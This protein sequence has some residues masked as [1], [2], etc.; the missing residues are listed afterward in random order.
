MAEAHRHAER[1]ALHEAYHAAILAERLADREQLV[2]SPQQEQPA[3]LARRL[4]EQMQTAP[5][6]D[7]FGEISIAAVPGNAEAAEA[8][9]LAAPQFPEAVRQQPGSAPSVAAVAPSQRPAPAATGFNDA[10]PPAQEWR[11]VKAN[12][13]VSLAVVD[14]SPTPFRRAPEPVTHAVLNAPAD[15]PLAGS[16]LPRH[17]QAPA[18]SLWTGRPEGPALTGGPE[19]PGPALTHGTDTAATSASVAPP[20]PLDLGAEHRRGTEP[21]KSDH[22]GAKPRRGGM[23]LWVFGAIAMFAGA[24]LVKVR[25]R[26]SVTPA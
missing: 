13:P 12:T 4:V 5:R 14:E 6:H 19:L 1:G 3:D 25:R 18:G 15:Q 2:F 24:V 9:A 20:P 11:G 22:A 10:F 8:P 17:L 7:P 16:S 26:R 21:Q 23:A